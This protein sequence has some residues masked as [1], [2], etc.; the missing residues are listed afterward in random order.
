MKQLTAALLIVAALI[1]GGC[2]KKSTKSPT[3]TGTPTTSAA[4]KGASCSQ[5]G[6]TE[7]ASDKTTLIC[8]KGPDGTLRWEPK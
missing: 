8:K 4:I 1:A 7:K 5:E 6:K 2:G 3:T